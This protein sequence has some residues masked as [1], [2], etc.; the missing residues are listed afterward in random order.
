MVVD[1]VHTAAMSDEWQLVFE[2]EVKH[3]AVVYRTEAALTGIQYLCN[4]KQ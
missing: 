4:A 2:T 3:Q 1:T